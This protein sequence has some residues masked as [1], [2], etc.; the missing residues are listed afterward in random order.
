MGMRMYCVFMN[1]SLI[2]SLYSCF[3]DKTSLYDDKFNKRS[4]SDDYKL[5]LVNMVM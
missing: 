1:V 4:I 5:F 2:T 3:A